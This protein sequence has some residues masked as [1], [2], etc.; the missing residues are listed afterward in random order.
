MRSSRSCW[1]YHVFWVNEL[2]NSLWF[3]KISS[4]CYKLRSIL[5]FIHSKPLNTHA[6]LA[7]HKRKAPFGL[8]FWEINLLMNLSSNSVS[9]S[10]TEIS[11]NLHRGL[12][13]K[14]GVD[15]VQI[16]SHESNLIKEMYSPELWNLEIIVSNH[17]L[18]TIKS[19][20]CQQM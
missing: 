16:V 3:K 17:D 10:I 20:P 14:Y 4:T 8:N 1:T 13:L 6:S 15:Q 2:H 7:Y 19:V 12:P 9:L 11:A 18:N 5:R